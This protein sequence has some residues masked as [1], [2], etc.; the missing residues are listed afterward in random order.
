MKIKKILS[1]LLVFILCISLTACTEKNTNHDYQTQN[2]STGN[3]DTSSDDNN[4]QGNQPLLYKVTDNNGNVLWL[5]GS[6]HIGRE[7]YYPLPDYVLNAFD[8]SDT[9]AVEAD[10]V[11]Y[12]KNYVQQ[13]KDTQLFMYS[14]GSKIYDH[15][16]EEL[17]NDAVKF[18]KD[19]NSYMPQYNYFNASFWYS[20]IENV[21]FEELGANYDLGIDRHLINR[22]NDKNKEIYEIESCEFQYSMLSNYSEELQSFL[23]EQV[24]EMS[25]DTDTFGKEIEK[26]LDLWASGNEKEFAE[27]LIEDTSEFSEYELAL[28][29]EYNDAM[30]VN[31]NINMTNYAETALKSGKEIFIC[32]GSAHVIG[33]GA[34]A[35]LMRERG[36]T[37]ELIK[38]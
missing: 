17:Y 21:I 34:I 32:V 29:N 28:Y 13:A 2:S 25:D 35:D 26:M 27:Y 12:E 23:L 7:E 6:I 38:E 3:V 22:A 31:R 9:L 37:V 4:S 19:H 20:I 5:F 10:I 11:A 16:S 36:Y 18:L 15:I 1:W 14:D 24:I 30:T 33:D 8:S